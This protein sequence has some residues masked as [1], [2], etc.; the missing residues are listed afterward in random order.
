MKKRA[1]T[2]A[3]ACVRELLRRLDIRAGSAQGDMHNGD[4]VLRVSRLSLRT[5]TGAYGGRTN[6]SQVDVQDDGKER[7]HHLGVVVYN[8]RVDALKLYERKLSVV[9]HW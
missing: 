6:L 2:R 1:G 3:R 4:G 9:N 8:C 7:I 5:S